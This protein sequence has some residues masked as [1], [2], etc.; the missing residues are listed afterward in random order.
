MRQYSFIDSI[1]ERGASLSRFY[2][3]IIFL[4]L[5]LEEFYVSSL[6]RCHDMT[7]NFQ[8]R[9]KYSFDVYPQQILGTGFK[10][11]TV[12]GIFDYQTAL[13]F[14]DIDALHQNV[15]QY[16]P[17]GTPNRPQDFDY[18]Y[19]RTE[20]GDN[21]IIGIPW[22]VEETVQLVNALTMHIT[23]PGVSSSDIDQ[24]RA[25]LSQNGYNNITITMSGS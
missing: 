3:A 21:T 10:N 2:V 15:Y 17:A 13:S 22:I 7:Y 24:V 19:L 11:V 20:S 8:N 1:D 25:C 6:T 12:Q 4:L 9:L 23:I 16:L 18:L 14:A 5:I